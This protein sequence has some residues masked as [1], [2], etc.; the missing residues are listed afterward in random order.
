MTKTKRE[1]LAPSDVFSAINL[2]V[3]NAN[4]HIMRIRHA[5]STEQVPIRV[6]RMKSWWRLQDPITGRSVPF[7]EVWWRGVQDVTTWDAD[8]V[9]SSAIDAAASTFSASVSHRGLT[10]SLSMGKGKA[11]SSTGQMSCSRSHWLRRCAQAS[12]D[13]LTYRHLK[14]KTSSSQTH[15]HSWNTLAT[16]I[17]QLITR[18][19]SRIFVL[20]QPL[21]GRKTSRAQT[22]TDRVRLEEARTHKSSVVTRRKRAWHRPQWAHLS[23]VKMHFPHSLVLSLSSVLWRLPLL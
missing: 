11:T 22:T 19:N 1:R 12:L 2:T 8:V 23:L 13:R 3:W 15:R 10:T 20:P 9:K 18:S 16:T 14:L 5:K 21:S 17:L 7:A 6:H 4:L